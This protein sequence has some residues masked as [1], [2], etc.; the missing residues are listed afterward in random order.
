[1][2]LLVPICN[3]QTKLGACSIFARQ[4]VVMHQSIITSYFGCIV[5]FFFILNGLGLSIDGCQ[6]PLQI[7]VIRHRYCTNQWSE[8]FQTQVFDTSG[9]QKGKKTPN[10]F[11]LF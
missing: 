11:S 4:K 8:T 2:N 10:Y 6:L 9:V 3:H 1:M 5:L 7:Y